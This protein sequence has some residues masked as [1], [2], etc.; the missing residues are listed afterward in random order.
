M[1][2]I[3]HTRRVLPD[4]CPEDEGRL[5][6]AR[7]LAG[8]LVEREI[9]AIRDKAA[10]EALSRAQAV[11]QTE[12]VGGKRG[13]HGPAHQR[14]RR[15]LEVVDA[16]DPANPNGPRIRRARL[17]DPLRRM[18]KTGTLPFRLFVAAEVFREDCA[19]AD[20]GEDAGE[21]F[22]RALE[23]AAN[24]VPPEPPLSPWMRGNEGKPGQWAAGERVRR[25]LQAIGI[26]AGGVFSWVVISRGTLDDYCRCK[27]ARRQ[28]VG[29][30]LRR[31]LARL[32]DHY[33]LG[34]V[35][36]PPEWN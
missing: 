20:G 34:D 18:V 8:N 21:S 7:M 9:R 12:E 6:R 31:A 14:R 1:N 11:A 24:G 16:L 36:P 35:Q 3:T 4:P 19:K 28:D 33:A 23:R 27:G 26:V 10:S 32:A 5:Q 2:A 22:G 29:E 15:R 30:T 13:D 17:R 25:A